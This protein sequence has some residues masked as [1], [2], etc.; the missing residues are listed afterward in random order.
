MPVILTVDN[1]Q[2]VV[3]QLHSEA[4]KAAEEKEKEIQREKERH[5]HSSDVDYGGKFSMMPTARFGKIDI[6]YQGLDGIIGLPQPNVFEQI[7]K[8]HDFTR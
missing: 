1:V 6:F 2:Q 3:E 4:E 5:E 8:E 7:R